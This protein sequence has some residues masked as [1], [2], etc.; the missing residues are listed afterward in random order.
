VADETKPVK[1]EQFTTGV[2]AVFGAP[3]TIFA[4]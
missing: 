2:V 1:L 4:D 3:I